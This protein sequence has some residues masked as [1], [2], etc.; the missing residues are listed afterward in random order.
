MKRLNRR[1]F[2]TAIHP[3]KVLQFGEGNFLRAFVDWAIDRL[4]KETDLAAGVCVVRPIPTEFP[5]SLNTQDGLY[6]SLIRGYDHSNKLIEHNE[7]I[8][9]VVREVSVYDDF[10][11]FLSLARLASLEFIFSNTTEAGIEFVDTD[12]FEDRPPSAFPAKLT[13]WLFQRF[14]HFEGNVSSGVTI[15]PCELIDRN[16]D[17]L[18]ECVLQYAEIWELGPEFTSWVLNAN[19]ICTTLVDRIVTGYPKDEAEAIQKE[20]GY[21]DQF[22]VTSEYF[23]LFVIEGGADLESRLRLEQSDLNILIT[24]DVTPYKQRKVAILNGAH[25]ALTPIAFLAGFD[26]VGEAIN[27]PLLFSYVQRLIY[28][29]VIPTLDLPSDDLHSFTQDVLRRFRNPFVRHQLLSI[30]LNS[31]AKIRSRLLPALFAHVSRTGSVPPLITTAFAAQILLYRGIRG[32]D[33]YTISDS[34][35]WNK[36]F[37]DNWADFDAG[38]RS[39]DEIVEE[40]LKAESHWGHDLT[41]IPGFQASVS[42]LLVEMMELG[43]APVLDSKLLREVT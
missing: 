8:E 38:N 27:D 43:V 7:I 6:T 20:L 15:I 34:A 40:V 11:E 32:V 5:P 37:K 3:I 18:L 29:E 35:F 36:L 13:R 39:A 2:D 21:E 30:S 12:K 31:M 24:D 22:M 23:H 25:T 41:G 4:N 26:T 1:N 33:S 10:D 42:A 17:R 14:E 28:D 16:G 19:E 9:C